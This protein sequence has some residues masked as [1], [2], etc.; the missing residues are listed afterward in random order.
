MS[1]RELSEALSARR[2]HVKVL[3]ISGY[4]DDAVVR[5]GILHMGVPFLQKPYTPVLLLRKVRQVLDRS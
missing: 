5:H 1:G 3:F 2:P 4:A